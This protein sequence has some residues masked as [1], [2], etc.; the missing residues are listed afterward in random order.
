MEKR[1]QKLLD[2]KINLTSFMVWYIENF[3]ESFKEMKENPDVQ[4][5]FK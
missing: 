3:P 4:Y 1:R 2:D 5:N